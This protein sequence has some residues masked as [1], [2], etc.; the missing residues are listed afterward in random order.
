MLHKPRTRAQPT[1][2]ACGPVGAGAAVGG[3]PQGPGSGPAGATVV[4]LDVGGMK[5]GACSA[6]VKRMLL[7]RPDVDSAA[8]NLLTETAAVRVR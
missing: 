3:P 4:V 6:A 8:V 7:T 5:C 1:C 2:V